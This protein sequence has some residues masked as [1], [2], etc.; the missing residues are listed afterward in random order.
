MDVYLINTLKCTFHKKIVF[1]P[2]YFLYTYVD[3]K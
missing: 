2:N 1:I 3:E